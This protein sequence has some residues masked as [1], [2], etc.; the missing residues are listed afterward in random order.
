MALGVK[1]SFA[2]I[3]NGLADGLDGKLDGWMPY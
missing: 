1:E 2:G 3:A